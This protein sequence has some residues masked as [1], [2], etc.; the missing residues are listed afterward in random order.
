M[1]EARHKD[2]TVYGLYLCE[3]S[4]RRKYVEI[5][6][7]F[8][9]ARGRREVEEE[10]TA[11]RYGVSAWVDENVLKLTVVIVIQLYKHTRTIEL[12]T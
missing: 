4:R 8:E 1:K 2:H 7:R 10:V 12:Y 9:V 5:E 3:M 6:S 11:N